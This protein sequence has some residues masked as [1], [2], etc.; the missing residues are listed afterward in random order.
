MTCNEAKDFLENIE[1]F[2]PSIFASSEKFAGLID[3]LWYHLMD[4]GN[5]I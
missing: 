2:I 3:T 1:M 4:T 5:L